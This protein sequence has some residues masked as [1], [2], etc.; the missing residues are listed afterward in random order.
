MKITVLQNEEKFCT[1]VKGDL[2]LW[3]IIEGV[4]TK[5]NQVLGIQSGEDWTLD[6]DLP[7]NLRVVKEGDSVLPKMGIYWVGQQGEPPVGQIIT[8]ERM[9][10]WLKDTYGGITK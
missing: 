9:G 3:R 4:P 1:L 2:T 6:L 5:I 10:R 7:P 8:T